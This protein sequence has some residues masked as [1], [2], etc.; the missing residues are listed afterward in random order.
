MGRAASVLSIG[1]GRDRTGYS[2]RNA[3]RRP[4]NA[5]VDTRDDRWAPG[6][7]RRGRGRGR[8]RS[9]GAAGR[10]AGSAAGRGRPSSSPG[11]GDRR[12]VVAASRRR[13]VAG[14]ARRHRSVA[15]PGRRRRSE[16]IGPPD[17]RSGVGDL[18]SSRCRRRRGADRA[19]A[20][21]GRG[22]QGAAGRGAT[23]P[24]GPGSTEPW[25]ASRSC[26]SSSRRAIPPRQSSWRWRRWTTWASGSTARAAA[27]EQRIDAGRGALDQRLTAIETSL[28]GLTAPGRFARWSHRPDRRPGR[29]R[30]RW[31]HVERAIGASTERLAL[32]P[33]DS[34]AAVVAQAAAAMSRLEGRL[35]AEF[36]SV[37]RSVERL[38]RHLGELEQL[39][40]DNVELRESECVRAPTAWTATAWT[41][42][43]RA[44]TV[45]APTVRGHRFRHQRV[46]GH[47][48]D[49]GGNR[50]AEP[51]QGARSS[52]V[53]D[54]LDAVVGLDGRNPH[55]AR[56]GGSVE[57]SRA[58]EGA[59][60]G[61][62][63]AW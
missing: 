14:G 59:R 16:R 1:D 52:R 21:G 12:G 31:D 41:A 49:G 61:R 27:I 25:P 19:G 13:P 48:A 53:G 46:G 26:G 42:T 60:L 63:A 15:D 3:R 7:D 32:P 35:D 5:G 57:L 47:R 45:P 43:A 50:A 11:R 33:S 36:G 17:P 38:D 6:Q 62:R 39:M 29:D 28:D 55:V 9:D 54:E 24:V 22:S 18:G 30:A 34:N 8:R 44:A 58:D 2:E 23:T 10:A 40:R 37:E 4:R 56:T 20:G 51:V